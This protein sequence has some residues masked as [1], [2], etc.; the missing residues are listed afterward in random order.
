MS[1]AV[2]FPKEDS[3]F[4]NKVRKVIRTKRLSFSTKRS[5]L[6]YT[7]NYIYFHGKRHP[8]TLGEAEVRAY[9]CP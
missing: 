4:L 5:Y 1:V 9:L 2:G 6:H 8:K 7:V 3:P